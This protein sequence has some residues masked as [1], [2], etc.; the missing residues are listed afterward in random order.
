MNPFRKRHPSPSE[1]ARTLGNLATM[2]ERERIRARAR[3]MRCDLG[4]PPSPAL[5]S[6]VDRV[7]RKGSL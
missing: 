6:G 3:Q 2:S 5:E 1:A 7:L 4:L